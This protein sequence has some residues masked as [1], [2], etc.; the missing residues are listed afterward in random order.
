MRG[1]VW[2]ATSEEL[3]ATILEWPAG[4]GPG[5]AVAQLDVVYAVLAGSLLLNE[6]ELRAGE[7]EIVA[8]GVTRTVVA[9]PDG[10]R[11]LTAHRRRGLLQVSSG[12]AR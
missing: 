2:G 1:P 7:A 9:G 5:E 6:H 12:P 10:V 8:G 11:Y 3:N 4:E